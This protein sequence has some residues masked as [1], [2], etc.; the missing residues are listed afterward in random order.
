[1]GI[2]RIA[3]LV[4]MAAI[5]MAAC[6]DEEATTV[7]LVP[8]EAECPTD[9]ESAY[10]RKVGTMFIMLG[11]DVVSLGDLLAEGD[12]A[13]LTWQD[14]ISFALIGLDVWASNF[15]GIEAPESAQEI[16]MRVATMGW[17]LESYVDLMDEGIR[18]LDDVTMNDAS[19]TM[20]SLTTIAE[21]T[22]SAIL[23]FCF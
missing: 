9:A 14:D 13:S 11:E 22:N 17:Q 3:L 7:T 6:G 16:Q 19:D 21:E 2:V 23:A 4:I 15:K 20:A 8:P 5:C 10:F 12:F 18:Q 1:M